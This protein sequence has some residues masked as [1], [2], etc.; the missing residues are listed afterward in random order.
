MLNEFAT[1][2]D[3]NSQQKVP[4]QQIW[5]QLSFQKF[6]LLPNSWIWLYFS[7]EFILRSLYS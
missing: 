6:T 1:L 2:T 7:N 4:K 3:P 5:D